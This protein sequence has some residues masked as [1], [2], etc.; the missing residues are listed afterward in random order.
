ML[1]ES[2]MDEE[3]QISDAASDVYA[4]DDETRRSRRVDGDKN[5]FHSSIAMHFYVTD[6]APADVAEPNL[7]AAFRHAGASLPLPTPEDLGGSLLNNAFQRTQSLVDAGLQL[8][9]FNCISLNSWWRPGD[10]ADGATRTINYVAA[11]EDQT[12]YL[13]SQRVT[14]DQL[15]DEDFATNE[16]LRLMERC[17]QRVCG[18]CDA[19]TCMVIWLGSLTDWC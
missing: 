12:F 2:L 11:N 14:K 18:V 16:M 7:T 13:E 10:G 15:E 4:E 5:R 19:T 3:P 6:A 8:S 17:H 1:A 9:Q